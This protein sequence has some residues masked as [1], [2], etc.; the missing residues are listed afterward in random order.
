MAPTYEP[1]RRVLAR[2]TG[3]VKPVEAAQLRSIFLDYFADNGHTVVPSASLIPHDQSLLFTV[4][5]M[6][7]FKPYFTEE[8]PAPYKRAVSIQKCFRAPDI[9][10]IGT[11]QRHLTFFEM[12]GNFSFGDYF[13]EGA[14]KYAW[15]LITEGFG[16]D[17]D[18][19]WVT[20]HDSDDQAEGLWRDLIGVRPERIQR[21]DEDNFWG[22][23]DSGP[24]GPCSEIFFDKGPQFG[25][26][27]GPAFGGEDRFIEF[28]NLVFMQYEKG[29]G[30]SMTELPKKNIDTGAGFERVL[31]ILN[32]V[33]SV[34][35]TDL[36]TPLLETASRA[37]K[38][39]YGKD[40]QTDV[41]I[42]RIAEHGRAMT[43]LVS[44]GVLPSNEGRGYV[45]RRIIRRAILA[46]RRSGSDATLVSSLVEA[47]I[48]KMGGAYPVLVKDRDL[49]VEVL[50]R[51]EAGFA[52]T[53]RTGLSLLEEARDEVLAS[54]AKIFPGDVA[55]KLHDTHGFPIE[56]TDE[57]VA[58]SG[59]EVQ[60]AA[61]DGAMK[62]QRE[63]ARASAKTL[64]LADDAQYRELIE[65][66]G[67]TEFVGRD[68]TRYSIETQVVAVLVGEDGTS[69]LFL[70]S[71]PFYAESG[72]QVGDTGVVVT[73]SGR[74][75]VLDTQNV[76]GG[77]FAHRGRLT[78]E[79]LAGQNALATIDATRREATRRNH[80]AT[81]LLHAG[82]RAVL[83]D[84]VRQQGSYV[85]PERL[86]FDFSHGAGLRSD[87]AGEILTIVNTD[88]VTNEGVETIQ[89][90]KQ[91]AETMGA[92]AFFGDKYGDRVR[93]VR[94]GSHSLE[95]CGGTHV[96]RLGDIGQIQIVSESS[97]GSNTR[98]IE[99]VSGLG[100]HR[101][102][103][104]M[105]RALGSVA[106]L[107]KTSLD[108]V[109]P[110]LERLVDRQRE[111]DREIATLRQAQLS[112]LAEQL[113]TSSAHDVLVARVDGY[114]GDQLRTLAQD[115][116]RRGR[117]AVVLVGTAEDK[118][119]VAVASDETLDAQSVV[120]QLAGF[121][122]GGGGGSNRLALAGGR[123]ASG[124]DA[125]LIAA[126]AL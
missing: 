40:E 50:E 18:R 10:I 24:C 15:G 113:H 7:P 121:V 97:I 51:E 17:P 56:L 89:T 103:H 105:E 70:D 44:D 9:D 102:S 92:V 93:V 73:E 99:A 118:V 29:P 124:I 60:R 20:V 36:F 100:A 22:M 6:V 125:L 69:E 123:D 19:L 74:F 23:G 28:W 108:D 77:L 110:S 43:M 75:E 21:L 68:I 76:A 90:S 46:A 85:G 72:G 94:A 39:T 86:R 98:R 32:G 84:H 101:R 82:L 117:R 13:K 30:G 104:E 37:L 31:S 87:E 96:E 79:I 12:M 1:F 4:A 122:G 34:F 33:E 27:G 116:Q 14:I 45:L 114:A 111:L 65:S 63:R 3:R 115:L 52:R 2:C 26:D 80:T 35:A 62:L 81:H 59:L 41:A 126:A 119:A 38:T 49:I 66:H 78:G 16:L 107:L 109:V 106:T 67:T 25:A 53:L 11:T 55:F 47:T 48:E 91:D 42:R 120:K 5:G 83:G 88:V 61:F 71:T 95:F 58:E 112:H 57:I 8:E 54:G 64:H